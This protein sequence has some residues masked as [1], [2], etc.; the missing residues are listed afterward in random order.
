MPEYKRRADLIVPYV[1]PKP[2][3]E[4]VEFSSTLASTMPMAAIFTRNKFVGW[5]AVMFS[6]QS[7]L[8]ESADA[9]ANSS[10]PGY[11]SVGMSQDRR[12]KN[13]SWGVTETVIVLVN[14][15]G[16]TNEDWPVA[17]RILSHP[18][19][20]VSSPS[21]FLSKTC[22]RMRDHAASCSMATE[23]LHPELSGA[24]RNLRSISH[25]RRPV[26]AAASA[27]QQR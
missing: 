24:P 14:G 10:T 1:E 17:N 8:G 27:A 6:I 3:P 19:I 7:W 18:N 13:F 25:C 26:F 2:N 9:R 15:M 22:I 21:G 5:F 16:T 12:N 11:F 20:T 4:N 23:E